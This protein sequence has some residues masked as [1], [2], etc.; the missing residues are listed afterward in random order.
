MNYKNFLFILMFNC[1]FVIDIDK[2]NFFYIILIKIVEKNYLGF[3]L[4]K[5]VFEKKFLSFLKLFFMCK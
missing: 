5:N 4:K 1:F 2:F 3:F